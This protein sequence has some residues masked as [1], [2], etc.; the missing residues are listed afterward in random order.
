MPDCAFDLEDEYKSEISERC[1]RRFRADYMLDLRVRV[2]DGTAHRGFRPFYYVL[3]RM[4]DYKN[5]VA[6]MQDYVFYGRYH[7]FGPYGAVS[8]IA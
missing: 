5:D 3:F 1:T 7:C 2:L 4:D 6:L 8:D